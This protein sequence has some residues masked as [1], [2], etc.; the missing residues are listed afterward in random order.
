MKKGGPRNSGGKSNDYNPL[1][2][3]ITPVLNGVEYLEASIQSVLNQSYPHIE[4]VFI[5]GGS[6]DGTLEVLN[7]YSA[8][9][10]DRIRF[11]SEP[12]KSAGEGWNKGLNM[13]RGGIL[14]WLGADDVY[15]SDAVLLVVE[16]FRANPG[17]YFVFGDC[18]YIDEKGKVIGMAQTEDFD[19]EEAINDACY[20]PCPSAFYKREIIDR[21]GL[22]DTREIGL[23][24]EFWIR[25]GKVFRIHRISKTLSNFRIHKDSFTASKEADRVYAMEGFAISRRHGGSL[26]S[27]RA[28]R[29]VLYKSVIF[30]WA[31]PYLTFIYRTI[32]RVVRKRA[33]CR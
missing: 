25:V 17:A 7:S 30:V 22:L 11:I 4:H 24:L 33:A 8:S 5:D 23:D 31:L 9:Y 21:V 12:D 29:Y 27:A 14:G 32:K 26:F 10:P 28:I 1:V 2:S 3:I 15:E 19:L 16:F 18:N 13:A 6:S 20:I